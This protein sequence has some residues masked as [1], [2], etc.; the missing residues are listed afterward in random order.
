MMCSKVEVEGHK[1]RLKG[2]NINQKSTN[3]G[4]RN[5]KGDFQQLRQMMGLQS[6][7]N[8]CKKE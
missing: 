8:Q 6:V 4:W 3:Q 5:T 2:E 7:I 1:A